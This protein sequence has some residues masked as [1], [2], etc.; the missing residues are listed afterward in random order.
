MNSWYVEIYNYH[1]GEVVETMGP[2]P[3]SRAERVMNGALI[4]LNHKEYSVRMVERENI[5]E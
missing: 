4:N 1:N 3:E 2:M 5:R